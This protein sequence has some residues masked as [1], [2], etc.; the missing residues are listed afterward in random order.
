MK[1]SLSELYE[2][3][4]DTFFRIVNTKD[5]F[6]EVSALA[7]EI[8]HKHYDSI[9]GSAQVDYMIERFQS[10]KAMEK[11]IQSDGYHYYR[12]DN[13]NTIAGYFAFQIQED[14]LFLSK[15]YMDEAYRGRNYSRRVVEFLSKICR[16]ENLNKIWLT[17]NRNNI[18]SI[19]IYEKLGFVKVKTLVS[20]IGS[21]Y[22][23]DDF[24]MEI[25][26]RG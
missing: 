5:Q 26:T 18:S 9:I 16:K 25:N 1:H 20:D 2:S 22:V 7:K 6:E 23:M 13:G 15:I 12:I 11:Q 21:G 8:W 3:D 14:A 19:A 24:V 10:P 4:C 17:V